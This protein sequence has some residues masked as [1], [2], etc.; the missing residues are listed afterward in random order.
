ML[1]LT[2]HAKKE[3]NDSNRSMTVCLHHFLASEYIYSLDV[4]LIFACKL[5]FY[6]GL[7]DT[8]KLGQALKLCMKV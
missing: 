6:A 3:M 4:S 8:V 7:V 2:C 5:T 1:N